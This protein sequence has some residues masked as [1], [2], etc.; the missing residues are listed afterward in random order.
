M[1]EDAEE[2]QSEGELSEDD[3]ET[4]QEQEKHERRG[5]D[6]KKEIEMLEKESESRCCNKQGFWTWIFVNTQ[7]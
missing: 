1:E 5:V 6:H 2:Y 7:H 3:E 4:L